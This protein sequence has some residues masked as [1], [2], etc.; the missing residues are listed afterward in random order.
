M[1]VLFTLHRRSSR[2]GGH[3]EFGGGGVCQYCLPRTAEVP[4]AAG[5]ESSVAADRALQ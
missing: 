3:R 4:G 2:R 5:T 1:P